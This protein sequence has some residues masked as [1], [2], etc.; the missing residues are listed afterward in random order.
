MRAPRGI[1]RGI[2]YNAVHPAIEVAMELHPEVGSR[3]VR[4]ATIGADN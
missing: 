2:C 1:Y 3:I 4:V